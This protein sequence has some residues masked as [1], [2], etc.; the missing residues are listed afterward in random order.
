MPGMIPDNEF[1]SW[2]ALLSRFL[3]LKPGQREELARELRAHMEDALEELIEAG[4]PRERAVIQVLEDFGDAAEVAARFHR[5]GRKRRWLMQSMVV[6]AC[7]L[8]SLAIVT[9]FG[10]PAQPAAAQD[11]LRLGDRSV[12]VTVAD[13]AGGSSASDGLRERMNKP[14]PQVSFD[15]TPLREVFEFLAASANLNIYVRWGD[16][17]GLGVDRD[18]PVTLRLSEVSPERV[19]RLLLSDVGDGQLTAEIDENVLMIGA[20]G[21]V[22]PRQITVIYDVADLLEHCD[23]SEI[24]EVITGVVSPDTWDVNGGRGHLQALSN[25][26]VVLQ[27]ERQHAEIAAL[28][29][30]IRQASATEQ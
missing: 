6:A 26:L 18:H 27:G 17:E 20:R 10:P 25:V 28:L 14:L 8:S 23:Q 7:M 22:M 9:S 1:E 21:E 29:R 13:R 24:E 2:L 3:R 5:I 15:E 11:G 4:V 19:L 30:A 12:V 16:F